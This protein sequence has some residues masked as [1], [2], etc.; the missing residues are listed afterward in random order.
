MQTKIESLKLAYFRATD[1]HTDDLSLLTQN[2][3]FDAMELY[4]DQYRQHWF[5]PKNGDFPP[6]EVVVIVFIP[7]HEDEPNIG[8][9]K[10]AY[11]QSGLDDWYTGI[12]PQKG[13]LK[14]TDMPKV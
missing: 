1:K 6:D 3:V 8:G 4:A 5:Y 10:L 14:W 13:V 7:V 2:M 12:K 9:R 11:Y